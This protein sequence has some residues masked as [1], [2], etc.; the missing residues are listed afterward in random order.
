MKTLAESLNRELNL[1]TC[2]GVS[3]R[4]PARNIETALSDPNSGVKSRCVSP[5]CSMRNRTTDIA[6]ASGI[7]QCAC[8]Y[9]STSKVRSSIAS[10]S[11]G[12]GFCRAVNW[13]RAFVYTSRSLSLCMTWGAPFAIIFAG[14]ART[15]FILH[16]SPIPFTRIMRQEG[17]SSSVALSSCP[18]S[19]SYSRILTSN[20]WPGFRDCNAMRALGTSGRMSSRSFEAG[21][22]IKMAMF[23]PVMFC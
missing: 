6:S 12:V 1:R 9:R 22:M 23:R 7:G 17:P 2:S 4:C 15:V 18:S 14:S 8:S 21:R 20:T 11:G 10:T 19:G 5:C 3:C 13:N 16:K